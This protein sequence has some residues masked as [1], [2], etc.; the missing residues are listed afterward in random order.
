MLSYL[1]DGFQ[2]RD[3]GKIVVL[4]HDH[5]FGAPLKGSTLDMAAALDRFLKVCKH[6]P[7]GYEISI[8]N[9]LFS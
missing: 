3:E 9:D 6:V 1:G 8:P 7:H 2:A 5:D 4:A